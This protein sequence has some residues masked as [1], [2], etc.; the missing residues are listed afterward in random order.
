MARFIDPIRRDTMGKFRVGDKVRSLRGNKWWEGTVIEDRGKI[1]YQGRRL[2]GVSFPM[3]LTDPI[4]T[5]VAEE[6]LQAVLP[7]DALRPASA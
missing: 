7:A 4:E 1:S 6:D 5:E 3:T 2:Y